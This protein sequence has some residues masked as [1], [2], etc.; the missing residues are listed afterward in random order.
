MAQVK[1]VIDTIWGSTGA[2]TDPGL[3]KMNSGWGAEIP[4]HQ[5][6]N[7]WQQR[8]DEMLTHLNEQGIAEWDNATTYPVDAWAKGSDGEVYRALQAATAQDPISAPAFWTLNL[9]PSSGSTFPLKIVGEAGSVATV[10]SATAVYGAVNTWDSVTGVSV[11]ATWADVFTQLTAYANSGK[12]YTRIDMQGGRIN[13]GGGAGNENNLHMSFDID[14]EAPTIKG[15][16]IAVLGQ[17]T[18][19][20]R[21]HSLSAAISAGSNA[22]A[23]TLL[24]GTSEESAPIISLNGTTRAITALPNS[25]ADDGAKWL[26]TVENYG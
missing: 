5:V 26:I 2:T 13:N 24:S 7:F 16:Y 14:W 19:V 20:I 21:T 10:A 3:T 12:R 18:S 25:D 6:Q 17:T 23:L 22:Y 11:G 8:A 4:T 15:Y 1:P 9:S